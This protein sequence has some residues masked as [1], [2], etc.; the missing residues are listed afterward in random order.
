[1]QIVKSVK[2]VVAEVLPKKFTDYVNKIIHIDDPNLAREKLA[3]RILL[4]T[5]HS[6][7]WLKQNGLCLG[8]IIRRKSTIPSAGQGAFAAR[9]LPKGSLITP[10]PLIQIPDR[11]SILMY[12]L[13]DN[14]E[15]TL[16]RKND[17]PIG[18]QLL[19]NYC[20]GHSDSRLLLFPLTNVILINHCSSRKTGEGDCGTKGP[21]AKIQWAG[22][23]DPRS[24]EW[25]HKS[26]EDI[27][28][29]TTDG[30]RGLSFDV[31]ALR[32]IEPGEE[33]GHGGHVWMNDCLVKCTSSDPSSQLF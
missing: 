28:Q 18:S 25:L 21:N 15:G 16:V 26:L 6:V 5:Q 23:W 32:D 4:N 14:G 12:E 9:F 13:V 1:L 2:P 11:K 31:V 3:K 27:D 7:E 29:L 33:V 8:N 22:S 24:A 19:L 17:T 30:M 20:F 10:A